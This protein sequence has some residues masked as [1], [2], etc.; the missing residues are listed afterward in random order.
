MKLQV[1]VIVLIG[2][3]LGFLLYPRT[4]KVASEPPKAV[5][6]QPEPVVFASQGRV[7]ANGDPFDVS[8]AVDGVIESVSVREGQFGGKD[9]AIARISCPERDSAIDSARA[10][11]ESARNALF[12]LQRGSRD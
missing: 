8:A 2:I 12:R 1:S 5:E 3:S 11:V 9:Q 7:E 10:A 6:P 4:G